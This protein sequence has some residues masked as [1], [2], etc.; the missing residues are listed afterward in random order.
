MKFKSFLFSGF[1][2]FSTCIFAQ[3]QSEKNSFPQS[4]LGNYKGKMYIVSAERGMIDSVDVDFL[5]METDIKNRWTY[6][7]TYKSKK[8][9]EIVKDYELVKPDSLPKS[10]YLLDEKD[11]ILIQHTLMGNTLYSNFIV[12]GTLLSC[13]LRKEN[14]ELFFEIYTSH[15]QASLSTENIAKDIESSYIVDCYPPFATQFVRFQKIYPDSNE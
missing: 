4:W 11:G 14:D 10:S 13:I 15:D 6:K 7:M 9:G 2:L 8:S 5:F 1:L 12:S 3:N